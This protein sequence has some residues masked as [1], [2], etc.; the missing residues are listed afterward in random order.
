MK[1]SKTMTYILMTLIAVLVVGVIVVATCYNVVSGAAK[2][3]AFD[4]VESVPQAEVGM[5]LGT[6]PISIYTGK[7]N[8]FFKNRILA[9]AA[10]YHAGKIRRILISGDEGIYDDI[11]EV[12]AMRDSLMAHGVPAEAMTLDGKG[13]RTRESVMRAYRDFG[14]RDMVIISQRFHNERALY[15]ADNASLADLHVT[16]FNAPDATSQ[17][18]FLTYLRELLARVKVVGEVIL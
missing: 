9:T 2:G 17:Y 12:T 10:L 1:R 6:S 11:N 14:V 15:I 4:Q 18:A 5:V 3:K 16:A 13:Y 7:E 8:S